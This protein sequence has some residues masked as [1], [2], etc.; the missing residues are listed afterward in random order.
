MQR[1]LIVEDEKPA[2]NRLLSLIG[3]LRPNYQIVGI[4]DSIEGTVNWFQKGGTADLLFLD[5]H[6]AD[7]NS[8]YIFDQAKIN[9]PIIFTTAYDQYA[10]K[11]FKLNSI[12]YLLKPIDKQDLLKSI[13]KFEKANPLE[14]NEIKSVLETLKLR[15]KEYKTRFLVR[16]VD[17]LISIPSQDISYFI[18]EEKIVFLYANNSRYAVD[19]TLDHLEEV[20]EPTMF[21]RIN[22]KCI[23][24]MKGIAKISIHFNGKLKVDLNPAVATDDLIISKE[25]SSDFKRWLDR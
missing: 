3:E 1:V 11:A 5:I 25:K 19:F 6:L 2:S 24:S 8:F 9:T 23:A 22:R 18:S 4:E 20:L 16:Y 17:K 12:D 7:G 15:N 10:I 21:F 13:E 14:H